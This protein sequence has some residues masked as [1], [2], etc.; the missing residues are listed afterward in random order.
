MSKV[1]K[2]ATRERDPSGRVAGFIAHLRMNG[3]RLGVSETQTAMEALSVVDAGDPR[4]SRSALKAVCVGCADEAGRFDALFDGYWM[5]GGRVRTHSVG[6]K[7][8]LHAGM[9]STQTAPGRENG[10]GGTQSSPDSDGTGDAAADGEGRLIAAR[11]SNLMKKD[12]RDVV[13]PTDIREAE[14][15]AERLGRAMRDRRSHRRCAASKGVEIDFRRLVRKSLSTGGEPIHLPR[16]TRPDRPVKLVVLCDVSGSMTAYARP[17]LAFVTGLMRHD[18][19]SDAYL[20]HTRLV[21][22]TEALRDP[23]PLRML[24]RLTLL[25]DGFGGGSMIGAALSS[26]ASRYARAFVD[27]R[28]IV[29]I[30]SD[31]YDSGDARE[32]SDALASLRRRGCKVVWLNPLK[33]WKDYAPIARGMEAALPHLDGFFAANTLADLADLDQ[34]LARL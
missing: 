4:A 14:A 18:P 6:A 24:N 27:G 9:Q 1:T 28:S 15:V 12:L 3:L 34:R 11:T 21:R 2:F 22:I 16:K 31:G 29:L 23:D 5:N 10:T 26:F 32:T 8:G 13:S 30:L 7:R 19:T 20:F 33:G 25:S 17:F